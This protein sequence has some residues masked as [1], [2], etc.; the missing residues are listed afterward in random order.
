MN[1]N[2]YRK[3]IFISTFLIFC[4]ISFAQKVNP[5]AGS[6]S[7]FLD[8]GGSARGLGLGRAMVAVPDEVYP[9]YNPAS[10]IT[11]KN[12]GLS[13]FYSD[14][15]YNSHYLD[16]M[17]SS[18]TFNLIKSIHKFGVTFKKFEVGNFIQTD[19]YL[20]NYGTFG[21]SQN[22][23][24]LTYS[25]ALINNFF[26]LNIGVNYKLIWQDIK[27][28]ETHESFNA[29]SD[30]KSF[31]SNMDWGLLFQP[32]NLISLR[33]LIPLRIG[34]SQKNILCKKIGFKNTAEFQMNK[35]TS[36]GIS[37]SKPFYLNNI[38]IP[39]L[40]SLQNN[41]IKKNK[42]LYCNIVSA[43]ETG[44]W[45]SNIEFVT[46]I[47]VVL[48]GCYLTDQN[49]YYG[50]GFKAPLNDNLLMKLDYKIPSTG[51]IKSLPECNKRITFTIAC[52][53]SR[54]S[55][56]KKTIKNRHITDEK[57]K[58]IIKEQSKRDALEILTNY[59]DINQENIRWAA[60]TL[61]KS[62]DTNKVRKIQYYELIDDKL[63]LRKTQISLAEDKLSEYK[64]DRNHKKIIK[65]LKLYKEVWNSDVPQEHTFIK[66]I[67][68]LHFIEL[69]IRVDSIEKALEVYNNYKE[70]PYDKIPDEENSSL[71]CEY[72]LTKS[73]MLL[74][75]DN[76]DKSNQAF[77]KA[78]TIQP[79]DSVYTRYIWGYHCIQ[80]E[81]NKNSGVS[82]LKKVIISPYTKP[83][84]PPFLCKIDK[85]KLNAWAH[86]I[87][88]KYYYDMDQK[89]KAYCE[90]D[91]I[92][93][94]YKDFKLSKETPTEYNELIDKY[95]KFMK[96][97]D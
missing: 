27:G 6:L 65:A 1:K 4:N 49:V 95:N 3:I 12:Y 5:I 61:A 83:N 70:S 35:I 17:V 57:S 91:E 60:F 89:I 7:D 39:F 29:A 54:N 63:N 40:I 76:W 41:Q 38:Q 51:K 2:F 92:K 67:Y 78:L 42:D 8:Y 87:L 33:W 44:I 64:K 93:L 28:L 36:L 23:L 72:F 20:N 86:L 13:L 81:R 84:F 9:G 47:A 96:N 77:K 82:E 52:F 85:N 21:Y 31:M 88:A 59:P 37:Y 68:F 19:E 14:V 94:Y 22:A 71:V 11:L 69:L 30:Y 16:I 43:L 73:I 90:L 45:Y 26:R 62:L 48:K 18:P 97:G 56:L 75:S 66:Q 46:R 79:D 32:I 15:F 53:L 50:I 24:F 80:A 34:F 10:L 74:Y 25:G 58:N 55:K